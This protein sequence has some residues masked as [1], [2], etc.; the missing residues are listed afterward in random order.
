M[1]RSHVSAGGNW[2]N[3][4][5]VVHQILELFT[6]CG[7]VYFDLPWGGGEGDPM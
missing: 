4:Q 6:V 3:T 1:V 5:H 7:C 2:Q